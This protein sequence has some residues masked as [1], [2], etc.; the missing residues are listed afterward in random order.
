MICCGGSLA[1]SLLCLTLI[2]T[3]EPMISLENFT[4]HKRDFTSLWSDYHHRPLKSVGSKE[5]SCPSISCLCLQIPFWLYCAYCD[6][7]NRVF[8]DM[9]ITRI[10]SLWPVASSLVWQAFPMTGLGEWAGLSLAFFSVCVNSECSGLQ[11]LA[12]SKRWISS[13]R[14]RPIQFTWA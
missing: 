11:G 14:R 10:L 8:I 13:R 4:V 7:G 2:V 3:I 1:K 12:G 6:W 9:C 5:T